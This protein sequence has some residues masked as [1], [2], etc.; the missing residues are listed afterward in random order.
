M[1]ELLGMSFNKE[2]RPNISFRGFRY[3]GEANPH[4]WGLAFYPDE[5]AQVF[6]EPIRARRSVLSEFLQDYENV[7]SRTFVAHVRF[8]SVGSKS[9]KNTHP[10]YRELNGKEYVFAHNGTLGNYEQLALGRFKPI[11]ETDSEYTFCYLLG[12]IDE[13]VGEHWTR[14]DFDWL[15]EKLQE[16][17]EYGNF[18]CIFSDGEHLF[19]YFD[20]GGY[21][22]LRFVHRK[23]P[24]GNIHLLDEDWEINLREEKDPDQ[25]GYIV[26][27]E[28]LTDEPWHD[29]KFGELLVFKNGEIIY[30]NYRNFANVLEDPLS[31]QEL[32]ILKVLRES[33]H[34][35]SL[36]TII[37]KTNVS[38]DETVSALNALIGKG[39]VR[40]DSRDNVKWNHENATFYT[41]RSKRDEI[42][43]LI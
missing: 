9:H 30:S 26:A 4:G 7:W 15:A 33:P 6:K 41:E 20:R 38:P 37:E 13:Q 16:I 14:E 35:L 17:N 40:Q 12:C 10:F 18:N 31:S 5:S 22:G 1:C 3:R 24:F 28:E 34:R 23:T 32:K 39:Y 43:A 36:R 11:G 27:T 29:F 25:R 2:V 42:D 8:T 19:C 21:N